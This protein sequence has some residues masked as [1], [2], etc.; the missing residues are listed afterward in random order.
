MATKIMV[1]AGHGGYDNGAQYNGRKEKDDTLKL[2]LAVGDKLRGYGYDVE[3]TRTTD[4]YDSPIKKAQKANESGADYFVSLHRNASEVPNRYNGVQT[5]IYNDSGI[6]KQM[7]LNVNKQLEELGF[8]NINVD[9]RPNLVVLRRT[10]MP[11]ILVEAGFINSDID[12]KL[13]DDKFDEIAKGIADGID[14]TLKES[15]KTSNESESVIQTFSRNK[16]EGINGYYDIYAQKFESKSTAR[17]TKAKNYTVM[18]NINEMDM[19]EQNNNDNNNEK[20]VD[21]EKTPQN[22]TFPEM[23][24]AK[25]Y[26]I[27][28]GVYKNYG[29]ARYQ[30]N[31]LVNAGYDAEIVQVGGYYQLRVGMFDDIE[32]AIIAERLLRDAGYTTLIV[33]AI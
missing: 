15:T 8:R 6:K 12:N 22:S 21:A 10:K 18:A 9:L 28:I 24:M 33:T 7:A 27:L 31:Q 13:F 14:E 3:Y 17:K 25:T 20:N 11:A 26:Q 32:D 2:A 19:F 16:D 5:L 4:V 1:D 29:T 23:N 30:M